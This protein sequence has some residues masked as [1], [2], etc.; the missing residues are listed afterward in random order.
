MFFWKRY[1][2]HQNIN[3]G[4]TYSN[5]LELEDAF[6]SNPNLASNLGVDWS[7]PKTREADPL[8]IGET[9]L[10]NFLKELKLEKLFSNFVYSTETYIES[11]HDLEL[12]MGRKD[13]MLKKLVGEN[14][15]EILNQHT[16]R[17]HLS[18][19][20]DSHESNPNYSFEFSVKQ[21]DKGILLGKGMFGSVFE[22]TDMNRNA[23]YAVK[24]LNSVFSKT[25][26]ERTTILQNLET[27]LT[28]LK[29]LSHPNIVSI[30]GFCKSPHNQMWLLMRKFDDSLKS[31]LKE[32]PAHKFE[33]TE[34]EVSF[35]VSFIVK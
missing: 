21:L 23:T 28:K 22:C 27:E 2:T 5:I 11:I 3:D 13:G 31:Y 4:L 8:D 24:I 30:I 1:S 25:E 6:R 15:Y 33:F 17:I 14:N 18:S 29:K 34:E 9:D 26:V 7:E 32:K 16:Q 35:P 19:N 20:S 10:L 12:V